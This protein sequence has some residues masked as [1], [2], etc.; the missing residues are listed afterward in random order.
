MYNDY[1]PPGGGPESFIHKRIIGGVKGFLT[2]GPVG[3]AAGFITGGGGSSARVGPQG[4]SIGCPP[5]EIRVGLGCQEPG[6]AGAVFTDPRGLGFAQGCQPGFTF[7]NGRCERTGFV[8]A[9]QRFVPGGATGT[10]AD[11][12]GEAVAGGF[13]MPAFV[14]LVVGNI[15][16]VDGTTGPILRCPSGTVLATDDLCY[17]K[18]TK[19]LAAHRKWKP[20]PPGFL[21]RRDVVCLRRAV[22][23]RKSKSNRAMFRELGLG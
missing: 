5:G 7:R 12:A 19:G 20:T 15:S 4:S 18:G 22:A 21:P 14:P 17:A 8:G 11:V 10:Q 2:G 16:K 23:I 1:L 6:R 13:N 9:A 3:A